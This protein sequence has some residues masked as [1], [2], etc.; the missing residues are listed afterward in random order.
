MRT[1]LLMCFLAAALLGCGGG[2]GGTVTSYQIIFSGTVTGLPTGQQVT[3]LGSLPTTGQSIPITISQNGVFSNQITLP[4]GFN[5]SNSGTANVTVSQQPSVGKCSVSYANTTV[6]NVSCSTVIGAAG[7]YVGPMTTP[8]LANGYGQ[9]FIQNNGNYWLMS[10]TTSPTTSGVT[11]SS[12][13]SGTGS[14]TTST[15]TSNNGVDIFSTPQYVNDIVSATYQSL[16][17][18]SGSLIEGATSYTLNLAAMPSYS[19]N[20]A[21]S[22]SVL[23]GTYN[24]SLVSKGTSDTSTIS[25]STT[26]SFNGST[27]KGCLIAGSAI[28]MTTGENAFNFSI[29]F[30]PSP[31]VNPSTTQTGSVVLITTT[32]GTQL[33]GGIFTNNLVNGTLLI[34]TKQ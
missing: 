22:L 2:G 25:I 3:L 18:F 32:A 11:Y 15:F 1:I 30:G 14:S 9:M 23:T 21:P 5:F 13:I 31:C 12:I 10:G 28:P 17:T 6:I 16:S 7:L 4:S 20:V 29:N 24:L 27:V 33:V 34:S 8:T 26:G 19:F